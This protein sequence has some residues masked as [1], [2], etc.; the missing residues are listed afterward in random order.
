V[1]Q[2]VFVVQTLNFG[3]VCYTGLT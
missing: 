2:R 1:K 3:D